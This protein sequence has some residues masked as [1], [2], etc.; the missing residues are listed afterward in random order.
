RT[1]GPSW[2]CWRNSATHCGWAPLPPGAHFAAG[3]G[4]TFRGARVG[5]DFGFGLASAHFTF[6]G[7]DHFT[8][9]Q[10]GTHSLRG[11]DA[12]AA[13]QHTT[14]VNN[15]AVGANNRIINHGIGRET[16]AAAAHA[17]VR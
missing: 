7:H 16:I 9:R 6:V 12:N 17:P 15:Y 5:A 4:W 13:F 1:W 14:V 10:V 8:A 11:N 2:V 3:L